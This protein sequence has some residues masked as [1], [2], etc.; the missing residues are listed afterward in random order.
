MKNKT[1]LYLLVAFVVICIIAFVFLLAKI[2][3]VNNQCVSN[4]FTYAAKT[5]VDDKGE[6]IYSVCSCSVLDQKFYFDQNGMYKTNPLLTNSL[7]L[8]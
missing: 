7:E 2:V 6:I 4:P 1:K 8:P 3:Q 5:I